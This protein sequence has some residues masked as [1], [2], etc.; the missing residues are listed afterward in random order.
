MSHSLTPYSHFLL[1]V[2]ALSLSVLSFGNTGIVLPYQSKGLLNSPSSYQQQ[3]EP[4]ASREDTRN[5]MP[6]ENGITKQGGSV[7]LNLRP[8]VFGL[9]PDAGQ[10]TFLLFF[11]CIM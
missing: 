8:L 3:L 4:D 6:Q 11:S 1:W 10:L 5:L 9:C 2:I 7:F